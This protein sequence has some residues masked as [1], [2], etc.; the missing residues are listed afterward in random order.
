MRQLLLLFCGVSLLCAAVSPASS[1]AAADRRCGTFYFHAYRVSDLTATNLGCSTAHDDAARV[2]L[3]GTRSFRVQGWSCVENR[4]RYGSG[5]IRCTTGDKAFSF[6]YRLT[7]PL[8]GDLFRPNS[9]TGA[10][11]DERSLDTDVLQARLEGSCPAG[12]AIHGVARTGQVTCTEAAVDPSK[13]QTRVS[14]TCT[15]GAA[16]ASVG[17]DGTVTC[18]PTGGGGTVTSVDSGTGLTGGPITS[19]GALS[20]NPNYRLPQSCTAG[21]VAKSDGSGAWLC[22]NDQ[23]SGGTVTQVNAGTGLSG[24]PITS[25]GT[26]SVDPTKT[27]SRVTGACTGTT[28]V[29][30]V[31]QAGTVNCS[32]SL[33]DAGHLLHTGYLQLNDNPSQSS[34][35]VNVGGIVIRATCSPGGNAL[36]EI[37][38]NGG[39]GQFVDYESR[40]TSSG[41]IGAT[42]TNGNFATIINTATNDLGQVNSIS[43]SFSTVDVSILAWSI[44]TTG[45][46]DC[47]FSASGLSF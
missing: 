35:L 9:I 30:S 28:A 41:L 13:V 24:G 15:G 34:N 6:T 38:S 46:V 12:Q 36:V 1:H 27:Q 2:I 18:A 5:T 7:R 20:I 10:Q 29:Q 25:T 14:G 43:N 26:L 32:S 11:I 31:N 42:V 47:V 39:G 45:G 3:G 23:D 40:S 16:I 33:Q 37:G 17:Q 22:A 8:T 19:S 4:P 44:A 21:Q